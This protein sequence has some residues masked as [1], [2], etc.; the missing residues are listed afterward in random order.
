[1]A[2]LHPSKTQTNQGSLGVRVV[3]AAALLVAGS[4]DCV[5]CSGSGSGYRRGRQ[6]RRNERSAAALL[7]K[8]G[9]ARGG[10]R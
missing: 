7:G 2:K 1:M 3:G 9:S 8:Q 5:Q 6:W 4:S 10:K